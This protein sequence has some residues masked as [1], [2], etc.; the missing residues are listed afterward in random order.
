LAKKEA[1]KD[2]KLYLQLQINKLEA[3]DSV[4]LELREGFHWYIT[5]MDH[6]KALGSTLN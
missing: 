2:T 5:T 3:L 6:L 1:S 4:N